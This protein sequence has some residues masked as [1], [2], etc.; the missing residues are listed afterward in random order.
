[1]ASEDLPRVTV[2]KNALRGLLTIL[3]QR[4]R[5]QLNATLGNARSQKEIP[6]DERN[7]S[8]F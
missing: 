8:L 3:V 1:M 6:V 7:M 4:S 2:V 5:D